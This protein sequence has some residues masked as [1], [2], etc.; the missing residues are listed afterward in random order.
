MSELLQKFKAKVIELTQ[1]RLKV[2]ALE[3]EVEDL[4]RRLQEAPFHTEDGEAHNQ[5]DLEPRFRRLVSYFRELGGR[6]ELRQLV[7]KTGL[8]TSGTLAQVR[9][10]ESLGL[11]RK[12]ERGV[13]ELVDR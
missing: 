7:P 2:T 10:L 9:M 11:V 1:A 6:A 5:H 13:Y 8:S 12:F 3:K 4:E